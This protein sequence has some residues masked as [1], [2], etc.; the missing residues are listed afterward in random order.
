MIDVVI[1]HHKLGFHN[2]AERCS[3]TDKAT[4]RRDNS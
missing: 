4:L 2:I 1:F 3:S